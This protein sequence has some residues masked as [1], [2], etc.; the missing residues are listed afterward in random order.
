MISPDQSA[1]K[2]AA[3]DAFRNVEERLLSIAQGCSILL[4]ADRS[5]AS[6]P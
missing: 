1:S 6:A 5:N 4:S 3:R 2:L